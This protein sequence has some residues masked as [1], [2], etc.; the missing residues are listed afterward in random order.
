M[1]KLYE[2]PDLISEQSHGKKRERTLTTKWLFPVL[3]EA[4][5]DPEA[6]DGL[7]QV[8]EEITGVAGRLDV[9]LKSGKR[10]LACI[11]LKAP[12][13]HLD[14]ASL[15]QAVKYAS[16][17]YYVSEGKLDPV[18]AICTNGLDAY[19][20]DPALENAHLPIN[21]HHI[22]LRH[23]KGLNSLISILKVRSLD[24]ANGS[25]PIIK[26][27][28]KFDPRPYASNTT[29]R[30][31]DGIFQM[32]EDL[33]G[34]GY[35]ERSSVEMAIQCLLLAAA[36]D[37]GIIPN[38]VIKH[39]EA[40]GDWAWLAKHCN[41]LFG[42]VFE[43]GIS[44]KKVKHIWDIYSRTSHFNVRLDILPA[45]YMGTVYEKII[46]KFFGNSTSYYTPE[47]MI[48]TVLNECKPTIRDS[49]LDPTCGSGAFL[50]KAIE[51]AASRSVPKRDLF[52]F[53]DRVVGVDRDPVAC[54]IAKVTLLCTFMRK[55]GEEYRRSGKPLPRPKIEP[56]CDF[57]DWQGGRFSLVIGNPP[58]ESIDALPAARK[59][60]LSSGAYTVY[61]DKNDQLCYIVEKAVTRHLTANGRFGFIIKLQALHATQYVNFTQFLDRKVETVFDY[62]RD[63]KF[64]NYAQSAGIVG[65]Q[66]AEAWSYVRLTPEVIA[67]P[68]KRSSNFSELYNITQGA[69]SSCNPVYK[70]FAKDYPDHKTVMNHP[71][72]LGYGGPPNSLV[73]MAYIWKDNVPVEFTDW[74]AENP[75]LKRKLLQRAD[76]IRRPN[77]PLS[78]R[79]DNSAELEG[80]ILITELVLTPGRERFPFVIDQ[81]RD[82]LPLTGQACISSVTE[83]LSHLKLLGALMIS[84]FFVPLCRGCNL[85]PRRAGGVFFNPKTVKSRLEIPLISETDEIRVIQ[86][87]DRMTRDGRDYN[88][89]E[90]KAIDS[91]FSKYLK[92]GKQADANDAYERSLLSEY[93]QPELVEQEEAEEIA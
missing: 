54:K 9:A 45:Q 47:D 16:S 49:I 63:Q 24:K 27:K 32:V 57:F 14:E 23:E 40:V 19:I 68:K 71:T 38:S 90:L 70:A 55:V 15:K 91:I 81:K 82:L 12:N 30:F 72:N 5:W 36:R 11:E 43:S 2:V 37:N 18:M 3:R 51:F 1:P 48:D 88:D 62:G 17:Y 87:I 60:D 7:H 29:E 64:G 25:L 84:S 73:P 86:I 74:L 31:E 78:W 42:D 59:R 93:L 61:Q 41:K 66:N 77:H 76:V 92:W 65:R 67:L 39:C 21:A 89:L 28:R 33:I 83:N 79:C 22:D 10:V 20:M 56:R 13:V 35:S 44:G 46:K 58:W 34:K 53:F 52:A 69:Q 4:G 8:H 6:T 26:S 75:A 80:P 85:I 50:S